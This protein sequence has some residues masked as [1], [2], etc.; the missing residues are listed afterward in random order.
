MCKDVT[1]GVKCLGLCKDVVCVL[2]G[3]CSKAV[4]CVEVE[5]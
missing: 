5:V 1:K 4:I 3:M 2:E